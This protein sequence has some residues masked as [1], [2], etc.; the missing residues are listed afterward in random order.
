M[1]TV[2][3]LFCLCVILILMAVGVFGPAAQSQAIPPPIPIEYGEPP[4]IVLMP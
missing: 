4:P 3:I 1:K 2:V